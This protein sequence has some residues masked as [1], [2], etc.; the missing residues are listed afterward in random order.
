[1]MLAVITAYHGRNR[2]NDADMTDLFA[3]VCIAIQ[4][5]AESYSG[6]LNFL[7]IVV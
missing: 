3:M 1:M 2:D 7:I 5:V 6:Q 4:A